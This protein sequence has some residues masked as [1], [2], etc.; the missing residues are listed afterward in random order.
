MCAVKCIISYA[1]TILVIFGHDEFSGKN[2]KI[3]EW[4]SL[5]TSIVANLDVLCLTSTFH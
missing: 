5:S 1:G 2:Y 4:S 3:D